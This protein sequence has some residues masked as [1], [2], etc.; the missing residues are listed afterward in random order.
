MEQHN[1]FCGGLKPP[2]KPKLERVLELDVQGD[3]KNIEFKIDSISK[4]MMANIP[5]ELLDLLEIAAYVYCADQRCSRGTDILKDYGSQWRRVMSFQIPVRKPDVW[6]SVELKKVLQDTLAFLSDETYQ[7]DF[8]AAT[9]PLAEKQGYFD[10]SDSLVDTDEIALFSGGLDSFAGAVEGIVGNNRKMTLVGHHSADKVKAVQKN[11]V[12]AL[13]EKGH[14]KKVNYISIAVRNKGS[15]AIEYTQRTRS[16]LFASLATCIMH[17]MGKDRFSFYENGVVS[18]NLPITKDI[19]GGRATRTTHPK[20]IEGFRQIFSLVL[21]K[22]IK[23]DHP[24]QWLTKKEIIEKIKQYG[25]GDMLPMTNS[26][27]RPRIWTEHQKHC[28]MCSQCIDRRFGILAAG[29]G[30]HEAAANY[31]VDLLLD[32][33]SQDEDNGMVM[34]ASYVKFAQHLIGMTRDRFATEYPAISPALRCFA[35]LTTAQAEE[36]IFSMFQRHASDVVSVLEKSLEEN[37]SALLQ[38]PSPIPSG[39]LLALAFNRSKVEP[40]KP[41]NYDAKLKE[42]LDGL[43]RYKIQFCEADDG[44]VF[45]GGYKVTGANYELIKKL[46]PNFRLKKSGQEVPYFATAILATEL[47]IEEATLY[48]RVTRLRDEIKAQLGVD[49]G[50]IEDFVENKER[51]GYRL[52]P[53]LREVN[54]L[55]DLED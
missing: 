28:G 52:N 19:R 29:L 54:S 23:V 43:K 44:L 25:M 1:I 48:R 14:D 8:V 11:L 3:G 31:M 26:C 41:D 46:L 21:N 40:I 32:D 49:Q 10:F 38:N 27:T 9:S 24:Y 36:K 12:N 16:F 30:E 20:V 18:L 51:D 17:M 55:A 45:K 22:D 53:N 15:R 5:D 6:N 13:A 2:T 33:R 37:S 4:A 47:S 7:F 50:M 34:A 42:T 39:S 35:P